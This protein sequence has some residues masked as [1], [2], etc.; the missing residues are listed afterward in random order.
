MAGR[1]GISSLTGR[2]VGLLT[3][4]DQQDLTAAASNSAPRFRRENTGLPL[5]CS[6][7]TMA[8]RLLSE[9]RIR[10]SAQFPSRNLSPQGCQPGTDCEKLRKKWDE[11]RS[12][13]KRANGA[14]VGRIDV[15]GPYNQVTGPILHPSRKI[16]ICGHLD[17]HHRPACARKI[18]SNLAHRAFRRPVVRRKSTVTCGSSMRPRRTATGSRMVSTLRSRPSWFRPI[19]CFVSSTRTAVRVHNRVQFPQP[20]PGP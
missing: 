10:R 20:Q 16:Y 8:C 3:D 12:E 7:C 13:K 9:G 17:G 19:S 2:R 11:R 4:D 14:S 5:R 15:V 1:S 18:V 6:I